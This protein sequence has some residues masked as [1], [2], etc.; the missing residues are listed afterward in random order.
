MAESGKRRS[1]AR[2][3]TPEEQLENLGAYLRSGETDW[4]SLYLRIRTSALGDDY[5]RDRFLRTP[6]RTLRRILT[7]LDHQDQAQANL[8]SIST[9]RLADL[10]L[11][12]AHGFSGSKK[13]PPKTEPKDWLPF[14]KY[15]VESQK[16]EEADA[17][18]KFILSEL[19]H[20]FAIPIYVF[21]A[22]N[23]RASDQE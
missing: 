21:V 1:R 22:L 5:P 3:L 20:K 16:A 9:A 18:T 2:E 13:A 14:P 4:D 10:L 17:P 12:V 8:D 15:R 19:A 11:K 23:G 7:Y 6:I